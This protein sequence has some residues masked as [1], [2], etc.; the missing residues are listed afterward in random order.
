MSGNPKPEIDESATPA[1]DYAPSW[2]YHTQSNERVS[3]A[4]AQSIATAYRAKNIISD[5]VAKIPFQMIRRIGGN[6]EQVQPDSVTRN[7]AY[8]LQ[9]S[10]N[11][12]GWVPFYFKKRSIEWLLFYGNNYIWSPMIGPRQLMILAASRTQPVFDM[13]G[14]LW[15]RHT[16]SN[17]KPEYIP[18]VEILHLMINPDETGFM[19]QSVISFARETFGRRLAAN[20]TQARMYANGFMPAAYV[21]MEGELNREARKKFKDEYSEAMSG[22][23]N[24]YSLAVFDQKIAKFEPINIQLRDAQWLESIDAT[25]QDI[26]NFFGLSEHMLNRGKEAYNSNEQ[27]YI[28]YLQGTLDAMLV[29]WEEAARIRWLSQYEQQAGYYFKFVRQALLRMDS[30]TRNEVYATQIQNGMLT[31]NEALE[32]EDMNGYPDGNRHYMAA[33]IQPIGIAQPPAE[34]E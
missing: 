27:K 5:D 34:Q 10:P 22:S 33:N 13:D 23:E 1:P 3:V 24:A 8:L 21:Q 28:E 25:D 29:P 19:G 14:N 26:C 31:P 11:L 30:K 16:F 20:K 4:G 7:M 9:V 2:G 6:S 32:K 12:W 15:Y 18:S 17:G